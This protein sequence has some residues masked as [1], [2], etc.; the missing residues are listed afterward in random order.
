M[1]TN[2]SWGRTPR[3]KRSSLKR[4]YWNLP[5]LVRALTEDDLWMVTSWR[6]KNSAFPQTRPSGLMMQRLNWMATWIGTIIPTGR[7]RTPCDDETLLR[8]IC[9]GSFCVFFFERIVTGT[10]CVT[11]SSR[12][13][14]LWKSWALP[15]F[16][17]EIFSTRKCATKRRVWISSMLTKPHTDGL[18]WGIYQRRTRWTCTGSNR[19]QSSTWG[20]R[21]KANVSQRSQIPLLTIPTAHPSERS[22]L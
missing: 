22:S 6:R 2:S 20:Q 21:L 10:F 16:H 18:F 9:V 13:N 15:H 19:Q 7:L 4:A 5:T 12:S 1:N 8:V 17:S 3:I 11:P 14:A